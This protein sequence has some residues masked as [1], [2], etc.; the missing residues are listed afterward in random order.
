[1][2]RKYY[3]SEERV[4]VFEDTERLYK[5]D[6]ELS[7]AVKES[8]NATR[9]YDE[10]A[11]PMIYRSNRKCNVCV[12]NF[13]TYEAAKNAIDRNPGKRVAVLN[14]ASAVTP[15]GGVKSGASAQEEC[16]CRCSTLLP[17]L[18]RRYLK[19]KYY[20]PNRERNDRRNTDVVIYTPDIVVF[21]SDEETPSLMDRKD[22]YKVDVLTCAAPDLRN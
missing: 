12:S 6:M 8:K 22:W 11:D 9:Y 20:Y 2:N 3:L 5:S 7:K 16:L 10:D 21:K 1:M 13:R 18:E 17:V 15:G 4:K 19:D 14:F